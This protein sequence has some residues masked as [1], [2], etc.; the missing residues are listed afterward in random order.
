M[1]GLAGLL[2]PLR[3]RLVGF[4]FRPNSTR[5]SPELD[6]APEY[7]TG[8]SIV[9][10]FVSA[11]WVFVALNVSVPAHC[12]ETIL[13][14]CMQGHTVFGRTRHERK[15]EETPTSRNIKNCGIQGKL[16]LRSGIVPQHSASRYEEQKSWRFKLSRCIV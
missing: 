5:H 10:A 7:R 8:H 3:I 9:L 1:L 4:S 15:G 2:L 11:A 16:A 12:F 14:I 13:L 6:Q